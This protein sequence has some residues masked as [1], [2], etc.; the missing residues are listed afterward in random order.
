MSKLILFDVDQTLVDALEHHEL[1]FRKAFKEVF[2]VDAELTEI[3]FYGKTVPNIIREL[4]GLKGIPSATI[5]SKLAETIEKAERFF[6]ESVKKG[7]IK[8]LP[9]V[10]E[11]LEKL[12]RSGHFLGIVTGNPEPITRSILEKA[13]LED[14]FDIFVY[15]SEGKDRI[16][17]VALAISRAERKFGTR[18]FGKNV[19]IVGD[20]IHDIESGK[21]FGALTIAVNT[22]FHSKEELMKHG[23]DY[24]FRDLTDHKILKFFN[25]QNCFNVVKLAFFLLLIPLCAHLTAEGVFFAVD[26]LAVG[27]NFAHLRWNFVLAELA[28]NEF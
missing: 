15:G 8:V 5:E 16:E 3:N 2:N 14:Y 20:S 10:T 6:R 25:N 17:L 28:P 12:K 27:R 13:K 18:F 11:L 22:G 23:P 21:P 26:N 4:A 19:A 24:L 7:E 1:A 9:G